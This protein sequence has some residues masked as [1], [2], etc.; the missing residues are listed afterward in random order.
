MFFVKLLVM[1]QEDKFHFL[2]PFTYTSLNF[3]QFLVPQFWSHHYHLLSKREGTCLER[4]F[5]FLK[6]SEGGSRMRVKVIHDCLRTLF[7]LLL[8]CKNSM[9][10]KNA[11][12]FWLTFPFLDPLFLSLN[13]VSLV[14]SLSQ[15]TEWNNTLTVLN[16]LQ[17]AVCTLSEGETTKTRVTVTNFKERIVASRDDDYDEIFSKHHFFFFFSVLKGNTSLPK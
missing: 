17:A 6:E 5:K 3:A 1:T 8:V 14:H 4:V 7:L 9:K 12:Y 10:K 16:C 13:S 11:I 15:E 2:F